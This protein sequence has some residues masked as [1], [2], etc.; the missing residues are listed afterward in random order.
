MFQSFLHPGRRRREQDQR[1]TD[2][3]RDDCLH[4]YTRADFVSQPVITLIHRCLQQPR[5]QSE[6]ER[7]RPHASLPQREY[8][9]SAFV[10]GG[11]HFQFRMARRAALEEAHAPRLKWF[12]P[13][14]CGPGS[15][16]R[17]LRDR[18]SD[19][20]SRRPSSPSRHHPARDPSRRFPSS[21]RCRCHRASPCS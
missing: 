12:S 1:E 6:L 7:P 2:Q 5:R 8:P 10:G 18:P 4:H 20:T 9:Q 21:P 14:H 13:S 11:V 16:W 3:R 17:R 15:P 19:R